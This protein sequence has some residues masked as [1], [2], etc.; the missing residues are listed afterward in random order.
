MTTKTRKYPDRLTFSV[1]PEFTFATGEGED[2]AKKLPTVKLT[3][4]DGKPMRVYSWM[5]PVVIDL[6][7]LQFGASIPLRRDHDQG[8]LVGHTDTIEVKGKSLV[9]T[10]TIS[11]ET[12]IAQEIVSSA[13]NG[14]PWQASVGVTPLEVEYIPEGAKTEVNGMSVKGPIDIVRKSSLREISFVDLGA[15]GGTKVSVTASA[16]KET[17]MDPENPPGPGTTPATSTSAAVK[18]IEAAQPDPVKEMRDRA[19]S[20]ATRI[21]E[22]QAKAKGHPEILAKAIA[23]G[24]TAD[25]TELEVLRA[26]RPAAPAPLIHAQQP[27]DAQVLE[28]AILASAKAQNL[29]KQFKPEVLEAAHKRFRGRIG[30]QEV[31]LEAAAAT[32]KHYRSFK[33]NPREVLEAAFSTMSI[34][35]ILA[36]VSNKF[37]LQGFMAVEQVWRLI[38]A[39]RPVSDFKTT[40]SYRLTGGFEFEE[41]APS[42]ELK[43]GVGGELS[44]TNQAKTYGKMFSVSRQDLINDDLGALSQ[45]PARI[46]RGAALKLNTVFWTEF[47]NNASFFSSG[48]ANYFEGSTTNL[49]LSSLQTALQRFRDQTDPDGKPMA[50]APRLLLVPTA[51]EVT[52]AALMKSTEVRD[53]TANTKIGTANPFVGMFNAIVSAYLSNSTI[54]GN[55]STA[56]YLLAD[57]ADVPVIEV[58]FLNGVEE[59]TVES[60]ELDFSTLGIQMRGYFDFGVAKQEYRGGVKSKG[61]A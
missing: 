48:N 55:S 17:K 43:H 26:S 12:P 37:L 35:G 28:C 19:A 41:V 52:A 9:A 51:L 61:A 36:N 2:G 39:T 45:L 42:G 30:L 20:E 18:P 25:R 23:D 22:I 13:R 54:S 46:G 10:G 16:N 4:Y 58:A 6:E 5:D 29:E 49:Q 53:T 60:A 56:W 57:P 47:M 1:R 15:S 44:Y 11:F 34:P 50:I 33:Q 27:V 40:T 38:S 7:G 21:A 31:M 14:F 59:P 32:G 8:K 24:W 3:A